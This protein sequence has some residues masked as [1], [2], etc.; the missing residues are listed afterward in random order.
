M[1]EVKKVK[2]VKAATV[3]PV[4]TIPSSDV[5]EAKGIVV[6]ETKKTPLKAIKDTL[7]KKES[8]DL[9]SNED[10]DS[11]FSAHLGGKRNAFFRDARRVFELKD[12]SVDRI[13][14]RPTARI[15]MH[16]QEDDVQPWGAKK[17]PQTFKHVIINSTL[18]VIDNNSGI[19]LDE[20]IWMNESRDVTYLND[21]YT[22]VPSDIVILENSTITAGY[23]NIHGENNLVDSSL[24]TQYNASVNKSNIR[25]TTVRANASI[26]FKDVNIT[27]SRFM[28]EAV[29][30]DDVSVREY[31][32]DVGGSMRLKDLRWYRAKGVNI[33]GRTIRDVNI[34]RNGRFHNVEGLHYSYS[35]DAPINLI[36][37]RRI[38]TGYFVGTSP[39]PFIR[40]ETGILV[41]GEHITYEE[42]KLFML[43]IVPQLK[44]VMNYGPGLYEHCDRPSGLTPI[45]SFHHASTHQDRNKELLSTLQQMIN[46]G[47]ARERNPASGYTEVDSLLTFSN[48]QIAMLADQIFS[49]LRL[50]KELEVIL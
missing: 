36:S 7:A 4:T 8:F 46:Y 32:I 49:R 38:D 48:S 35:G 17:E 21:E 18:Y 1:S 31:S 42:F 9:D 28:G 44:P 45:I 29:T 37:N 30:L 16:D 26:L 47:H 43:A 33:Y 13:R 14:N 23:V 25:K 34:E 20:T 15:F 39:L 24:R 6:S 10:N 3:E 12:V 50:F 2:E 5:V 40:T 22:N 11:F 19:S 27:K 41:S